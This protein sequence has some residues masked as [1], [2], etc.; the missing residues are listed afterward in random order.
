[1]V[2]SA[3]NLAGQRKALEVQ[4]CRCN[5]AKVPEISQG[6]LD[7]WI[8]FFFFFVGK[9]PQSCSKGRWARIWVTTPFCCLNT[10]PEPALKLKFNTFLK[11]CLS[12]GVRSYNKQWLAWHGQSIHYKNEDTARRFHRPHSDQLLGAARQIPVVYSNQL[13]SAACHIHLYLIMIVSYNTWA[14]V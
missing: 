4:G 11:G 6:F 10:L 7:F 1:M 2:K 9:S 8:F 12:G 13:L 3:R 5:G 14:Y